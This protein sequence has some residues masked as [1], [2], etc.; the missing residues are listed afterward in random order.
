M[1]STNKTTNYE[2]SQFIG[3]DKPAWLSDYNGDMGKIDAGLHTAQNTATGADGKADANTT[4]IG[5]LTNLTTTDKTDLVSAINE[6]DSHADTAQETANTAAGNAS[7]AVTTANGVSTYISLTDFGTISPSLSAGTVYSAGTSMGYALNANGSYGKI[8]GK[9]VYTSTA[10]SQVTVTLTV[11]HLN[12]SSQ[13]TISGAGWYAQGLNGTYV[14][15]GSFDLTL[16]TDHTVT[17]KIPAVASG[18]IVT[19]WLPPCIYYFTDFGDT[20]TPE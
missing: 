6:V 12:V 19:A 1:S 7:I 8:Y 18:G 11:A 3:S 15:M 2:L 13:I 20:P 17:F 9:L 5:T 14:A 4:K 16:N 10:N